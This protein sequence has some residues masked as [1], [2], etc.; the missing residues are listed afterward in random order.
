MAL[1]NFMGDD[2]DSSD[3]SDSSS[4]TSSSSKSSAEVAND[5]T[6]DAHEQDTERKTSEFDV[7][8]P[9]EDQAPDGTSVD[10]HGTIRVDAPI[11]FSD[12]D[13]FRKQVKGEYTFDAN[14]VKFYMPM[15]VHIT[16][17]DKFQ[18]GE[19]WIMRCSGAGYLPYWSHYTASVVS[20]QKQKLRTVPR[21]VAMLD[22]GEVEFKSV[23]LTYEERFGTDVDGD[24]EV[25]VNIFAQAKHTARMA[26]ANKVY[27]KD[28]TVDSLRL[29]RGIFSQTWLEGSTADIPVW[30]QEFE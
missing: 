16:T 7:G 24:T 5:V 21:E 13:D 25:F 15:F 20:S 18:P 23:K 10:D 22:T 1:D 19:R 27:Q 2:D 4:S 9:R 8:A 12:L 26:V 29:H 6:S 30:E 17:E 3:D 11:G 28:G 14:N